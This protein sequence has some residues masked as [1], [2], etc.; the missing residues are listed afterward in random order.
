MEEISKENKKYN[1]KKKPL[2]IFAGFKGGLGKSKIA[3]HFFSVVAYNKVRAEI[4]DKLKFNIVEIDDSA[5]KDIWSSNRVLCNSYDVFDYK[6]AI[7]QIQTTFNDLNTVEVIDIGS[8]GEKIKQ[9]LRH[10]SKMRLEDI[11]ELHFFVPTNRDSLIFDSTKATLEL[12]TEIFNKK[13]TLIYNRVIDNLQDEFQ[14]Y[15][16][17]EK[18]QIKSRFDE[19]KDFISAEWVIEEDRLSLIENAINETKRSALDFYVDANNYVDNFMQNRINAMN[20]VKKLNQINRMY[21]ISYDYIDFFKKIKFE[22]KRNG[23]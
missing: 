17:N 10:I 11:F 16:G 12:I 1:F 18:W 21:D 3:K 23:R 9:L 14:V 7:N 22:V 13:S 6:D 19:I 5:T 15:F 8:G 4:R 2:Y 20:D